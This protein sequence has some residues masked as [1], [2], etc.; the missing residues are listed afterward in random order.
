MFSSIQKD[1]ITFLLVSFYYF[2]I[3]KGRLSRVLI[4]LNI[5]FSFIWYVHLKL[6]MVLPFTHHKKI[7]VKPLCFKIHHFVNFKSY[8]IIFY[9]ARFIVKRSVIYNS[10]S[11]TVLLPAK[12]SK[13]FLVFIFLNISPVLLYICYLNILPFYL[14]SLLSRMK[15]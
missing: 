6:T 8:K 10:S 4:L 1:I 7:L 15:P 13:L 3:I 12:I 9:F 2:Q 14:S 11:R 5:E